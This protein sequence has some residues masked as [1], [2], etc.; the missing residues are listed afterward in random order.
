MGLSAVDHVTRRDEA[1]E[2][3]VPAAQQLVPDAG[4]VQSDSNTPSSPPAA[5]AQPPPPFR[6]APP[7]SRPSSSSRFAGPEPVSDEEGGSDDEALES[8]GE[9]SSAGYDFAGSEYGSEEISVAAELAKVLPE[10]Y[11]RY[12]LAY[13][14]A[15]VQGALIHLGGVPV[16]GFPETQLN[17]KNPLPKLI[18][19]WMCEGEMEKWLASLGL[20]GAILLM[21]SVQLMSCIDFEAMARKW[22]R[23]GQHQQQQ[24]QQTQPVPPGND[25]LVNSAAQPRQGLGVGAG[26]ASPFAASTVNVAHANQSGYS[27][28]VGGPGGDGT[29]EG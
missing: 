9:G 12:S 27:V 26:V 6:L 17:P 4:E 23:R 20:G 10:Q 22:E 11:M 24:G 7:V 14:A 21:A 29:Y 19:K 15:A 13:V 18:K 25:E 5:R 2:S 3:T 8:D 28:I 1:R 16:K